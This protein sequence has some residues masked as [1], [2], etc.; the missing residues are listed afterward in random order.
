MKVVVIFWS[1]EVHSRHQI[2]TGT[3]CPSWEIQLL[4][5]TEC[6]TTRHAKS[7]SKPHEHQD[8]RR[9]QQLV[10]DPCQLRLHGAGAG[11]LL[12]AFSGLFMAL[13]VSRCLYPQASGRSW[14]LEESLSGLSSWLEESEVC[15]MLHWRAVG[16]YRCLS[17]FGIYLEV[18]GWT[19]ITGC[20]D[21]WGGT[22]WDAGGFKQQ[23]T[24][25]GAQPSEHLIGK[26]Y[27]Y[28]CQ[29]NKTQLPL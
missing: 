10:A 17:R 25:K 1:P 8:R 9:K 11:Q 26:A 19:V 21:R 2:T 6:I 18:S 3:T 4:T 12:W 5:S 23:K 27:R 28:G 15:S 29:G 7:K 14:S 20:V 16:F 13:E 24:H 22:A